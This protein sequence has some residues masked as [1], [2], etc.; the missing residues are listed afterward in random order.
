MEHN[1]RKASSDTSGKVFAVLE[2]DI[3]A[4]LLRSG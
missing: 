4:G 3:V 2:A 1:D